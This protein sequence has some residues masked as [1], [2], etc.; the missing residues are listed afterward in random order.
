M[1]LDA[2]KMEFVH[3]P[4]QRLRELDYPFQAVQKKLSFVRST[5]KNGKKLLKMKEMSNEQDS[6]DLANF[7]T[8]LDSND[9]SLLEFY[10]W[11]R[12]E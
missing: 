6:T 4:H 5:I 2:V 8:L 11:P 10:P 7:F 1:F 3:L 9:E 12:T